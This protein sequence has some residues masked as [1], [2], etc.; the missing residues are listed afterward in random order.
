M[1]ETLTVTCPV[2]HETSEFTWTGRINAV[3]DPELK[4]DLLDGELFKF[5]CPTCGATRQLENHF[6]Y[7]DPTQALMVFLAPQLNERR[8][9]YERILSQILTESDLNLDSYSLRLV[10]SIPDLIEKIQIFDQGY[11][12]QVIEIVKL[13]TDGLFAKEKPDVKVKQRHYYKQGSKEHILYVTPEGQLLVDFHDSLVSF[14]ENK[15]KKAVRQ[16]HAGRF[17]L[18]DANWAANLLE[19]KEGDAPMEETA[20]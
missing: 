3:S 10:T 19:R 2:C 14:A 1:K 13:L 18:V 20:E 4:L 5:V 16:D 9:N 11:N 12:D 17:V 8:E 6:L 15:Y 7:H